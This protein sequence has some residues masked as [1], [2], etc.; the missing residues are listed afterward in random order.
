MVRKLS[1]FLLPDADVPGIDSILGQ[2]ARASGILRQQQVPVVVE[3]ADDRN[4]DPS[5]SSLRRSR[6]RGGCFIVVYRHA[7]QFGAGSGKSGHLF[8]GRRD[9]R[10]CPC[11]SSTAP[12]LVHRCLRSHPR[13]PCNALPALNLCHRKLH[14]NSRSGLGLRTKGLENGSFRERKGF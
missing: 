2:R 11:S 3:I 6:E 12:R 7:N 8:H 1:S 13:P 4:A 5:L 9:I 10:P 14:F